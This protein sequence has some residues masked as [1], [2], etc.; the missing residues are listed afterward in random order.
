MPNYA[1][2]SLPATIKRHYSSINAR[3][4]DL[5]GV[6]AT[7]EDGLDTIELHFRNNTVDVWQWRTNPESRNPDYPCTWM[8]IEEGAEL[9]SE[10]SDDDELVR[11]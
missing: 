3:E 2:N 1:I 9:D 4:S 11:Q 8:L 6:W 7:V 10:T 5:A